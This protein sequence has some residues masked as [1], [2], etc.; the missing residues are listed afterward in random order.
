MKGSVN[1]FRRRSSLL[2]VVCFMSFA[3]ALLAQQVIP[4][5]NINLNE[6]KYGQL[7]SGVR[8]SYNFYSN[9]SMNIQISVNND[10]SPLDPVVELHQNGMMIASDDD[11]GGFPNS[12]LSTYVNSGYYQVIVRGFGDTSSGNYRLTINPGGYQQPQY[13]VKQQYGTQPSGQT[14]TLGQTINANLTYPGHRMTYTLDISAPT[15]VVI[16]M[17]DTS[18]Q[19]DCYLEL[20]D[21]YGNQL[22]TDDDGGGFPNSR[23][24]YYLNPG[25]YTI[26]CR[27]LGDNSTGSFI[28][29][30]MSGY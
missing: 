28:V 21:S 2:M 1:K 30:V 6:T 26:I 19:I 3:A 20:N 22:M 27:D 25:R 11:G 16:T 4:M 13:G 8:H 12:M 29:S 15:N 17:T 9:S 14:I 10:G 24:T 5:G 7:Y 23:L 18:G